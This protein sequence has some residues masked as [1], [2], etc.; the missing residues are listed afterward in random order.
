VRKRANNNVFNFCPP[1]YLV[2]FGSLI[3]AVL[4][5]CPKIAKATAEKISKARK[6]DCTLLY[7]LIV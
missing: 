7:V 1:Q 3:S 4:R 5:R 6:S 2:K